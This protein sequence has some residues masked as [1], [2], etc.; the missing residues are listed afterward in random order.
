MATYPLI[1]IKSLFRKQEFNYALEGGNLRRMVKEVGPEYPNV[2]FPEPYDLQH[3]KLPAKLREKGISLVTKRVLTMDL[4]SGKSITKLG[5]EFLAQLAESKGMTPDELQADMKA[6]MED[7]VEFEKMMNSVP[8]ENQMIMIR[9][10]LKTRDL[11]RNGFAL[12]FNYTF[13]F[14][15]ATIP[16][17]WCKI[18]P[19]GFALLK[20]LYDIHGHQIFEIG[21]FNADPHA[22][23]VML[24]EDTGRLGLIDYGQLIEITHEERRTLA[25]M[26]VAADEGDIE[27]LAAGYTAL[28]MRLE[29]KRHPEMGINPPGLCNTIFSAHFGGKQ[30]LKRS[31][32][33]FDCASIA[34][35]Q[36]NMDKM[37]H[38]EGMNPTYMMVQRCSFCLQG[39]GGGVGIPGINAIPLLKPSAQKYLEGHGEE[40]TAS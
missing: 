38:F 2:D 33:Y 3:P 25:R 12:G 1:P 19:N 7:P 13:G 37:M 6:K 40:G 30:G 31:L 24:D 32:K 21:A 39:V 10:F 16:Y 14:L 4:C 20:D 23:N 27:T 15:G 26:F 18:P 29:D 9:Q 28:G 36:A 22:G 35:M 34:D 11:I 8:S 5:K 17:E